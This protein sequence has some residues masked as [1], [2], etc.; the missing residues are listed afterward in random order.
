MENTEVYG[1]RR[2]FSW[3]QR[4]GRASSSG[5][6]GGPGKKAVFHGETNRHIFSGKVTR[7]GIL[8]S[9]TCMESSV[10]TDPQLKGRI[11]RWAFRTD[12]RALEQ[13]GKK[14]HLGQV[15]K[16]RSFRP[17]DPSV[18][19]ERKIKKAASFTTSVYLRNQSTVAEKAPKGKEK[20]GQF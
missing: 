13:I 3:C 9:G 20:L 14:I 2:V 5:N 18:Y 12:N 17:T 19:G 4:G 1:W 16:G 8:Q 15:E 10:P 11:R 6:S 7:R